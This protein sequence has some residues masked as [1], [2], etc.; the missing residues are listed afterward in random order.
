MINNVFA[1]TIAC[2]LTCLRKD[3]LFSQDASLIE[4]YPEKFEKLYQPFFFL[5]FLF[6]GVLCILWANN[7]LCTSVWTSFC[8][9]NFFQFYLNSIS[10][11]FFNMLH[12]LISLFELCLL[13]SRYSNTNTKFL[14]LSKPIKINFALVIL[15]SSLPTS[16]HM[17]IWGLTNSVGRK[18]DSMFW[19]FWNIENE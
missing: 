6:L 12:Y 1:H 14:A 3:D 16:R 5:S 7:T 10:Y 4:L 9:C 17:R 15:A 11:T 13:P 18:L 8:P 2:Y 19:D